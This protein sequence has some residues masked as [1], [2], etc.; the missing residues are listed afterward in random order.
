MLDMVLLYHDLQVLRWFQMSFVERQK[1]NTSFHDV[2]FCFIVNGNIL[3][4]QIFR[5]SK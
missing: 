4:N 1:P 5:V 2:M 3:Q